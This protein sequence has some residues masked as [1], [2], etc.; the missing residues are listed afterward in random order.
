MGDCPRADLE[1][2]WLSILKGSVAGI[3]DPSLRVS[4][5]FAQDDMS[6]ISTPG[7]ER[8]REDPDP[9]RT[10]PQQPLPAF[11]NTP[12]RTLTRSLTLG[13]RHPCCLSPSSLSATSAPLRLIF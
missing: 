6:G 5:R 11:N 9:N 8:T 3:R 2:G 1:C 7:S 10:N 13:A 4:T 12:P